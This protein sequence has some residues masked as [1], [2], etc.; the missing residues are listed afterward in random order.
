MQYLYAA[1]ISDFEDT[2]QHYKNLSN[3][4]H[5]IHDLYLLNIS[6][7]IEIF[8][9]AVNKYK[10]SNESISGNISDIYS[11]EKFSKNQF[12]KQIFS[13][14]KILELISSKDFINWDIDY[15]FVNLIYDK[16]IHSD[17]YSTYLGCEKK[18]FKIDLKFVQDI[19]KEIIVADEK[20][21]SFVEEKNIY[22]MDD[23]PLVNT[24]LLKLFK[25][26]TANS[27]EK[28]FYFKL[29]SNI[30]DK[31]YFDE[32]AN[33]SLKNFESNNQLINKYITNWDLD[34][35][36]KIDL[37]IINLA[38]TELV[39][40]KEIPIKVSLNEYIEI[41][42]DYSTEKSSLFINGILDKIVKDLVKNNSLIKEGRGLRE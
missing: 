27:L 5:S 39:N 41:S 1:E 18:S 10:I 35:L 9:K 4:I 3:S 28:L 33:L 8:K 16:I 15:K 20:F 31:K 22:W 11:N 25:S 37:V 14:S 29:F 30:S 7:L 21:Q 17:I 42:K 6:L 36:A 13:N 32:L 2:K 40:F 24:L 38:I 12:L 23:Y 19:F 34:R 26:S